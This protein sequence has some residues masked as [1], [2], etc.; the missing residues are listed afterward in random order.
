VDVS[1]TQQNNK[2]MIVSKTKKYNEE[3][4]VYTPLMSKTWHLE[5]DLT[6]TSIDTATIW[7]FELNLTQPLV[8]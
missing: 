2:A 6:A 4:I 7:E 1:E 5:H 3:V 8:S